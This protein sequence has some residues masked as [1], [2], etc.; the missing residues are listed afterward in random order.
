MSNYKPSEDLIAFIETIENR[1]F[2]PEYTYII[3]GKNGPTGKTYLT[4]VLTQ[5]GYRAVEI[6][7]AVLNMVDYKLDDF[8]NHYKFDSY[9][10]VAV[11]V[12]N[13]PLVR[14]KMEEE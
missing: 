12:L 5:N 2:N 8:E 1:V 11:V 4:N 14:V 7:E 10:K 3:L 6:T 13:K 9:R